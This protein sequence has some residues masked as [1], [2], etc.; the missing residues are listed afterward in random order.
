MARR[1]TAAALAVLVSLIAAGPAHAANFDVNDTGNAGDAT[2]GNT[3]CATSGG[4][5]TLRAAVD[6]S[7]ALSSND[8]ISVR[9]GTYTLSGTAGEDANAGGDLDIALNG[10]LTIRGA[11]ART[12]IVQSG[13]ADRV[14]HV[15]DADSVVTISGLTITGGNGVN[16]GGGILSNEAPTTLA[17]SDSTIS[18]NQANVADSGFGGEGG[19]I[20]GDIVQLS[21]VTLSGNKALAAGAN[22]PGQGGAAF[23]NNEPSSLTNV[24]VTGNQTDHGTGFP[25]QGGGVFLND[26]TTL[27]NVTVTNN[28]ADAAGTGQGGG[29]FINDDTTF[30]NTVVSGNLVGS[31]ASECFVND[32]VT[33][34]SGN[35]ERGTDC[36]FTGAANRQGTDPKLG[37]LAN[38][39]GPTDT[40]ALLSGSPGI[41]FAPLA[42]CPGTDQRGVSRPQGS[43]CDSGAFEVEVAKPGPAPDPFAGCLN[44][45]GKLK[46]TSLG[47]AKLSRTQK[48]QRA[49]FKGLKLRTRKGLDRYCARGGGT[50]RIGYPTKRLQGTLKR[51]LRRKVKGRVVIVLTSSARFSLKGLKRGDSSRKAARKLKHERNLKVGKNRWLVVAGRK[52]TLLVRVQGGKV[53]E[54]GIGDGRLTHG[55]KATKR[56][57]RAWQIS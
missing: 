28:Q 23:I 43:L 7:N 53:R 51:S 2:P 25:G 38:N 15:L 26:V 10:T 17:I 37:A 36:G 4:V 3:V 1:H 5:C 52:V 35:I 55:T 44:A 32:T 16:Q 41:D 33:A 39:G 24:T 18:N 27:T 30:R 8:V 54:I 19:G 6:E 47:P 49:K 20:F 22:F 45:T 34:P 48:A 13:V 11:S 50:F 14:F 40:Q 29:I 9:A 57:L 31:T 56:F 46:G 21:G 42:G 12:T